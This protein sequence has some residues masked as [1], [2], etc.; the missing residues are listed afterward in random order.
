MTYFYQM[1]NLYFLFVLL[2]AACSK[3]E[4]ADVAK[5]SGY[6]EIQKVTSDGEQKKEYKMND[7]F[8]HFEIN[9]KTGSRSKV[10]P[11]FDGTFQTNEQP[12]YFTVSVADGKTYLNYKTQYATWKEQIVSLEDSV[13]VTKN[14][15]D[16]EF[17]YKRTGP[18]NFTGSGKTIK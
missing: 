17:N 11:Q 6:W 1:K 4:P 8:D 5:L 13:L 3:S 12:E 2:F 14:N 18:L 7:T 9:G 16:L 10:L 15:Q